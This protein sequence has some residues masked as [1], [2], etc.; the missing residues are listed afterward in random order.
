MS[1]Y[2]YT[3]FFVGIKLTEEHYETSGKVDQWFKNLP[4]STDIEDEDGFGLFYLYNETTDYVLGLRKE[5]YTH[6]LVESFS[7][8]DFED[9]LEKFKNKMDQ[10]NIVL[11][12]KIKVEPRFYLRLFISS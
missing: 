1:T 9:L 10:Y 8:S 5:Q 12:S 3:Q 2:S 11:P 7:M 6:N 4:C